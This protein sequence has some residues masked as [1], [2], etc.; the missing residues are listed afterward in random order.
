M[1]I[2]SIKPEFWESESLGRVSREARLLFVGLF[3]CCDDSGRTRASSRLLASRLFPYDDD[4]IKLLPKWIEELEKN[5]CVRQYKVDGESY[6]D[7]P[8]WL[9][10]QKIDKPSASKLPQFREDSRGFSKDSLGTGNGNREVDQGTGNRERGESSPDKSP[11]ESE[12]HLMHGIEIPEPLRTRQCVEA[13]KEWLAYKKENKSPYKPTG[14]RNAV[15]VWVND[16]TAQTFPQA[17]QR[18][19]ANGWKGIH[20]GNR[21]NGIASGP[22]HPSHGANGNP[23]NEGIAG[24]DGWHREFQAR[25]VGDGQ[26]GPW[27]DFGRGPEVAGQDPEAG[28][29]TPPA[30]CPTGAGR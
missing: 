19:I 23:R 8:K 15:A 18:S 1:R 7:I 29:V 27:D 14:L 25:A 5:G 2:R 28:R 13:A 11:V 22:N 16:F 24:F 21:G 26:H 17:V 6:L 3:S 20:D 9:N 12:W 10:H 30:D 4:A